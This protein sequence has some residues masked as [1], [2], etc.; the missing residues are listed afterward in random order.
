MCAEQQF[1][2]VQLHQDAA[3]APNVRF[4]IPAQFHNHLG[5]SVLSG[6]DDGTMV[7]IRESGIPEVNELNV[8]SGRPVVGMTS[9]VVPRGSFPEVLPRKVAHNPCP[10]LD[11]QNV[12]RLEVRV[13][14]LK[15]TMQKLQRLERLLG[16]PLDIV[17][18]K[19]SEVVLLDDV[20]QRTSQRLKDQAKKPGVVR[21]GVEHQAAVVLPAMILSGHVSQNLGLNLRIL[22]VS[23][24][25]A[26]DFDG[27][28][29]S[30]HQISGQTDS[31]KGP[32]TR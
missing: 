1:S 18:P 22:L 10:A 9:R 5:S 2:C 12:L 6:V 7:L 26:D 32:I 25:V 16:H 13:R 15:T 23:S 29:P 19:P 27:H 17:Q 20:I 14:E 28:L 30:V 4:V 24:H 3:N 21:E 8:G 31:S 11:E